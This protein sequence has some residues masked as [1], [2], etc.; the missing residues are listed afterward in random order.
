MIN[1]I[2]ADILSYDQ[3]NRFF[4]AGI[5]YGITRNL[6]IQGNIDNYSNFSGVSG[7]NTGI[8]QILT[9]SIDYTEILINGE[10][11]GFGKIN[12]IN[13]DSNNEVRNKRY[14]VNVSVYES[15]NTNNIT[16]FYS[17]INY[18]SIFLLDSFDENIS[19]NKDSS[20]TKTYNH[21]VRLRF[22][23]GINLTGT[24]IDYAKNFAGQCFSNKNL[25]GFLGSY[26]SGN[27]IK[28]RYSES[29]NLINSECSFEET[30]DISEQ[31]G[32]YSI[33][34][35]HS[36]NTNQ[37]GITTV[38]ENGEI[39]GLIE[40][41]W[42]H[43]YSGFKTEKNLT[44]NRCSGVF[45]IYKPYNAYDLN[46]NSIL[47]QNTFN[48]LE[49][50]ISYDIQ[51]SNNPRLKDRYSWTYNQEIQRNSD[52]S[53]NIIEQGTING[54]GKQGDKKYNNA[55]LG[56]NFIETGISLRIGILY[57]GETNRTNTL[58]LIS[59]GEGKSEFAGQIDYSKTYSD[60]KILT[61]ESGIK[62]SSITVTDQNPTRLTN[63]FEIV[64]QKELVQDGRISRLGIRQLN[65]DLLGERNLELTGYS[66]YAK[67]KAIEYNP[68]GLGKD[69]YIQSVNYRFNKKRNNFNFDLSWIFHNNEATFTGIN[70]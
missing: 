43:T 62:R 45:E 70:L 39:E 12:R 54:F 35:F 17:G 1:F 25:T 21:S 60:N 2:D 16:G 18:Q 50:K 49:N 48:K 29:Y 40:P 31:S 44:F 36:V 6:S 47:N 52:Q 53:I 4:D 64:N 8:N 20:S 67:Q 22:H 46:S 9:G 61:D 59:Q 3:E 42:E 13:F 27:S 66:Q 63:T 69:V 58:Y 7:I 56:W 38:N 26:L 23:S 57:S 19:F 34:Y 55:E 28:K 10:S 15:G 51:Y 5:R 11:W 37:N 30:Y 33:S 24:P 41:Y 14:T 32:L 65:I 68:T